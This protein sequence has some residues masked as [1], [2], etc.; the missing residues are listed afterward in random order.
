MGLCLRFPISESPISE[1]R[2]T[3]INLDKREAIN[4]G[5]LPVKAESSD[6]V[7]VRSWIQLL[8]KYRDS[9]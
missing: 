4:E 6:S 2:V 1:S 7:H 5:A 8:I 9:I 3:A